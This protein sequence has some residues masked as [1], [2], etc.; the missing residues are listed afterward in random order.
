M[1][2]LAS[3]L[4]TCNMVCMLKM[5]STNNILNSNETLHLSQFISNLIEKTNFADARTYK[6]LNFSMLFLTLNLNSA[7]VIGN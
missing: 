5:H 6:F 2:Q 4:K 1:T 7:E 3:V